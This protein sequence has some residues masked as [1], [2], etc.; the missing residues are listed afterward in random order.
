MVTMYFTVGVCAL[1][2]LL[3]RECQSSCV[4]RITLI[5]VVRLALHVYRNWKALHDADQKSG[6]GLQ[7]IIRVLV[8]GGYVF[9]GMV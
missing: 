1:I 9:F 2:V 4:C 3:E 8:F 6:V 7:S 5:D